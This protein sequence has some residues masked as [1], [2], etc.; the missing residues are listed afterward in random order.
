M[1]AGDS[2]DKCWCLSFFGFLKHDWSPWGY[3]NRCFLVAL[4]C[5][6]V[7]RPNLELEASPS[8]GKNTGVVLVPCEAWECVPA[9]IS[10]GVEIFEV[11]GRCHLLW[12]IS[13]QWGS[14]KLLNFESHNSKTY[15]YKYLRPSFELVACE[16]A[17]VKLS[18]HVCSV[19]DKP[20]WLNWF[21]QFLCEG[22]SSVNPKGFSYSYTWSYILWEERTFFWVGLT[23]R[24][25]CG[26]LLFFDWLYFTWGLTSFFPLLITLFV[27]M[28]AFFFFIKHGEVLLINQSAIVFV[29]VDF[30]VYHKD[31]NGQIIDYT[32]FIF[33]CK[34][35]NFFLDL[36]F[37][38]FCSIIKNRLNMPNVNIFLN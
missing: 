32:S 16:S 10:A 24:K 38:K 7:W 15:L 20:R 9:A 23:S 14:Q 25:L 31:F 2:F 5:L 4:C 3:R 22:L 18:W 27:L 36:N 28:H 19:W 1:N 6:I 35:Q 21:K 8:A 17:W 11:P 12:Q 29:F 30:D 26:F 37:F 13:S 34:F 33:N